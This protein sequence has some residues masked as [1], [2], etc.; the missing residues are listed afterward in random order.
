VVTHDRYFLDKVATALLVFE[1]DGHVHRHEGGYE[2]Y[3]RLREEKLKAEAEEEARRAREAKRKAAAKRD[4]GT[5]DDLPTRKLTYAERLELE[6]LE[7]KIL[8]AEAERDRLEAE[9]AD[10][11]LYSDRPD[12]VPKLNESFRR[13]G[14]RV[15]ALYARWEELESVQAAS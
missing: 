7:E 15:D 1:G 3:R 12:E 10:P 2:L 5:R 13:A 4:A 9:L 11:D 6:G 8:E 14:E